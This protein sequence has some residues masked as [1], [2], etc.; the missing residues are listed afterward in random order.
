VYIYIYMVLNMQK[1]GCIHELNYLCVFLFI[2]AE[3][4]STSSLNDEHVGTRSWRSNSCNLTWWPSIQPFVPWR[5]FQNDRGSTT[6]KGDPEYL[7]L[8]TYYTSVIVG[9]IAFGG[10]L[11]QIHSTMLRP[12]RGACDRWR[13]SQELVTMMEMQTVQSD[14]AWM[15][16]APFPSSQWSAV[17]VFFFLN[18]IWH[19]MTNHFYTT[20]TGIMWRCVNWGT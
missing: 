6:P 16:I 20:I 19:S 2:S 11:K 17:C 15:E 12:S 18:P 3:S 5:R 1:D 14:D 13:L 9:G 8:R 10:R 4:I 7:G